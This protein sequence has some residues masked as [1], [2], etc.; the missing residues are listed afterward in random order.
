MVDTHTCHIIHHELREVG[1]KDD[2]HLFHMILPVL[3]ITAGST[4]ARNTYTKPTNIFTWESI[5]ADVETRG[6]GHRITGFFTSAFHDVVHRH[7]ITTNIVQLGMSMPVVLNHLLPLHRL[8]F[9][10]P[11]IHHQSRFVCYLWLVKSDSSHF[12]WMHGAQRRR[13]TQFQAQFSQNYFC[14]N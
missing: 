3:K 14:W 8:Q 7:Q 12:L 4:T 11:S 2:F 6:W 1:L 9:E 10:S 13:S 5:L